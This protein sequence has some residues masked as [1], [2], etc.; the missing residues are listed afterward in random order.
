MGAI[1]FSYLVDAMTC[2]NV[3]IYARIRV[4]ARHDGIMVINVIRAIYAMLVTAY[5]Y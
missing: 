3:H 2:Y 5:I 1:F 4:R